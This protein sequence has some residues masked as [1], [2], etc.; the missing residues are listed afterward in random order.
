VGCVLRAEYFEEFAAQVEEVPLLNR[1]MVM[2][3]HANAVTATWP[4][5]L[6]LVS[7][8]WCELFGLLTV[9]D[10]LRW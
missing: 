5:D 9:R 4:A 1:S 10:V 7:I 3:G 6:L 8:R 2:L